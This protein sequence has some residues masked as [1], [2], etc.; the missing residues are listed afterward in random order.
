MSS[1]YQHHLFVCT[2][3]RAPGAPRQCCANA[4]AAEARDRAKQRIQQLKLAAP[5]KVRVNMAG[6]MERCEEGPVMVV[7]P[8]G[9]WYRYA[10][11]ADV[12]EI[13][14]EHIVNGRIVERLRLPDAPPPSAPG[15]AS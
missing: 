1:Y 5:G 11:I 12:D 3:Q 2:N 7:Y 6:C 15:N 14:D 4:G 8:E 13:I 9:I 10:S